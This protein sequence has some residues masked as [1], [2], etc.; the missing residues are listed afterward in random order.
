MNLIK[1]AVSGASGLSV[2]HVRGLSFPGRIIV[3]AL[4]GMVS[5]MHRFP[6]YNLGTCVSGCVPCWNVF[7]VL[8]QLISQR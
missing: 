3:V 5:L 6:L 4:I 1:S 7:S 8:K 2:H